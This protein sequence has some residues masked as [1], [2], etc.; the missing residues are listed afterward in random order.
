MQ[1]KFEINRIKIKGGCQ[2]GS[3][4]VTN[5]SKSDLSLGNIFSVCQDFYSSSGK[6]LL[7]LWV[8]IFTYFFF[9]FL[10]FLVVK[11]EMSLLIFSEFSTVLTSEAARL[12]L[13]LI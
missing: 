7:R 6:S 3:K 2:L 13:G 8:I 10:L 4:V 12:L 1:K 5:N 9:A 11:I